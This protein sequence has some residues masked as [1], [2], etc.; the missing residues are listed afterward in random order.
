MN[1]LIKNMT[2]LIFTDIDGTFIN[3][4]TFDE[5]LNTKTISELIQAQHSVVF[6]TSKTFDEVDYFQKKI[7][8]S[9][10]FICETGGGIYITNDNLKTTESSRGA[11]QVLYESRKVTEY[12]DQIQSEIIRN[13][14]DDLTFFDDLSIEEQSSLSGLSGRDLAHASRRDFSILIKWKSTKSKYEEF[15]LFL[16]KFKLNLITGGRFSHICSEH[17]KGRATKLFIEQS[18]KF[19]KKSNIVTV[20][21]GDSKN[22]FEMLNVVDFPCIVKSPN[23]HL[24]QD[25]LDSK[26]II[27]SDH[28]APTGWIECIEKVVTKIKSSEIANV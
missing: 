23:N 7:K 26:N 14:R 8:T 1:F 28:E 24:L 27:F 10:S 20:A 13:Y 19:S 12:K 15:K 2:L 9:L 5:G 3:N 17:D 4:D 22:D 18:K 25:S 11:Y 21:I 16:K 6:N